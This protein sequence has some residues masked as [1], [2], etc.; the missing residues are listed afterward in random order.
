MFLNEV[1]SC[2]IEKVLWNTKDGDDVSKFYNDTLSSV[3][4]EEWQ[5]L[6]YVCHQIL[7]TWTDTQRLGDSIGLAISDTAAVSRH[8]SGYMTI[9][10]NAGIQNSI[11]EGAAREEEVLPS[12][13][14]V[15]LP[16]KVQ[17]GHWFQSGDQGYSHVGGGSSKQVLDMTFG[18]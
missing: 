18:G 4:M 6:V 16:F 5:S 10:D 13:F 8:N 17:K 1:C 7:L 12:W 15:R 3:R 9:P 14:M 2:S 11:R